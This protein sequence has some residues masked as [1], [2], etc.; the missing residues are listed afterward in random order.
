[1]TVRTLLTFLFVALATGKALAASASPRTTVATSFKLL[2]DSN[3]YL[4]SEAELAAGQT[5]PSLPAEAFD[6]VA[7]AGLNLG[8]RGQIAAGLIADGS[9]AP[10]IVRYLRYQ[11]ESYTNQRLALN[12][13]GKSG[14]WTLEGKNSVLYTDGDK[15]P[16][17][18]N[19]LG[20]GPALGGEPIRAR[21]AQSVTKAS[22]RLT[23]G[24]PAG[25]ARG[26]FNLLDQDFRTRENVAFGCANYVDRREWYAGP[27]AG[28]WLRSGFAL[29]GAVRSGRQTQ[30]DLLGVRLNY[31]N[32]FTRWLVGVEGSP[33]SDLKLSLLAGPDVRRYGESVR[34]GFDRE[35][36]TTYV[37]GSAT[38][39]ASNSDTLTFA[40]RRWQW[41]PGGGRAAY[42]DLSVDAGWKHGLAPGWTLTTAAN[43]HRGSC[44]RYNPGSPR[45]D[46][47]TT[48]NVSV[49]RQLSPGTTL[50]AG[51][52]HDW[53]D[54][55][56]TGAPSREYS[57]WIVS[58]GWSRIW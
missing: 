18:F 6:A 5:S 58:A 8:L 38:W 9:Y 21:R 15:D 28:C 12:L 37:E 17:V 43:L 42:L 10:E 50:E 49:T 55:R 24:L 14:D 30:A 39:T 48:G 53:S 51:V 54:S 40:L 45:D 11:T 7:V 36:T 13:S 57:R 47:I 29:V 52:M 41:L 46:L 23:R 33:R 22:W 31:S 56:V 44:T 25:F 32:A 16:L 4:Q 19:R 35:Q 3:V 26:V 27:E 1:M 34:A 2:V 20:G